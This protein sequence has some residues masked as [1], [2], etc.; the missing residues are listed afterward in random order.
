MTAQFKPE[1]AEGLGRVAE[2]V[3]R[4]DPSLDPSGLAA[5]VERARAGKRVEA[6]P[7]G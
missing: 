6:N 4:L 5:V 2:V 3:N 1:Y 7:P